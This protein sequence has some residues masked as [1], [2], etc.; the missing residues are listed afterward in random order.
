MKGCSR[1]TFNW[2]GEL[3]ENGEEEVLHEMDKKRLPFTKRVQ[4]HIEKAI[5]EIAIELPACGQKSVTNKLKERGISISSGEIRSVW[6][7]HNLETFE[8]RLKALE[9]KIAQG[10]IILTEGQ[11]IA[12]EKAK[13]QKEA[14]D[15]IEAQYSGYLG[16]QDTYYVGYIEGIGKIYQ[17]TFVDAYSRVA[18]VKLYAEKTAINANYGLADKERAGNRGPFGLHGI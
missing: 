11:R 2:L 5:I 3:Y 14:Q 17:Q 8:K 7:R 9:A 1:G 18:F 4:E 13:E 12:L 10:G 15:E 16:G 6:K